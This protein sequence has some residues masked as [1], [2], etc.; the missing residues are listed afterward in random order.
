MGSMERLHL[1][2]NDFESNIKLGFSELRQDEDF[3]DVTLAC[4]SKQVKA[5][6]VILSACSPFFRSLIKSVSHA[7]PLLY[8]RGIKFSHLEALLSFMYNGEVSVTQEELTEFLSIAKELKIR[9]LTQE[10]SSSSSSGTVVPKEETPTPPP[11]KRPRLNH[12][13]ASNAP[14]LIKPGSSR[15][16]PE[17]ISSDDIEILAPINAE[18]SQS[19]SQQSS[20]SKHAPPSYD[21][22]FHEEKHIPEDEES[23]NFLSCVEDGMEAEED[24]DFLNSE[25]QHSS[26]YTSDH[27][28]PIAPMN[29]NEGKSIKYTRGNPRDSAHTGFSPHGIQPHGI[30]P[31]R[32]QPAR[33]SST[34]TC[35]ASPCSEQNYKMAN[36]TE[37]GN[38]VKRVGGFEYMQRKCEIQVSSQY[39]NRKWDSSDGQGNLNHS[40]PGNPLTGVVRQVQSNIRSAAAAGQDSTRSI[41]AE[42]MTGLSQDVLQRLPKRSTLEDN[43]EFRGL[44][45]MWLNP[46]WAES[47]GLNSMATIFSA[48]FKRRCIFVSSLLTIINM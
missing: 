32:G 44:N 4:E 10:G 45:S 43:A 22:E 24:V 6:K 47:C 14:S 11:N 5:H 35:Q 26:S 1:K 8:L 3:Y 13:P 48:L 36:L 30:Q 19:L 33:D 39:K 28:T 27:P 31:A 2:W 41:L 18:H 15:D 16:P 37:R 20:S 17:P 38:Q 40:H 23:A 29:E 21:T 25:E 12:K 7:H 46:V 9:G 34:L 42:N